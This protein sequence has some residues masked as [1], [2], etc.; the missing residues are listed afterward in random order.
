MILRTVSSG[1][2]RVLA[3]CTSRGDCELLSFLD[4][5]EG[6]MEKD[7]IRIMNLLDRT[8]KKGP[9]KR[10]EIS[11]QIEDEVYEFIQGR[12]RVLWFYDEG[13][14]VICTHGFV[15]KTK[16]TPRGEIARA[17][18]IRRRYIEDK[19]NGRIAIEE[20]GTET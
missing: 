11:H 20:G 13:R 5:M 2:Y 9:S 14:I 4:D 7:A 18:E 1:L 8:A 15:K 10:T 12:L 19:A 3:A 6:R 17:R 16:K